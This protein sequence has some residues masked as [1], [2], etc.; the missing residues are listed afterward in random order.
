MPPAISGTRSAG[1]KGR[2]EAWTKLSPVTG[3]RVKV[4]RSVSCVLPGR[5]QKL[6]R[7]AEGKA[8]KAACPVFCSV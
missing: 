1:L 4:G 8:W 7:D 2:K 5:P 3:V 6:L